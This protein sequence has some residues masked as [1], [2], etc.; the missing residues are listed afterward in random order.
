MKFVGG[1]KDSDVDQAMSKACQKCV[2]SIY[3]NL[4][5]KKNLIGTGTIVHLF[6]GFVPPQI[7]KMVASKEFNVPLGIVL[8]CAHLIRND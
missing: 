7:E 4:K 6:G 3:C 8:T 2:G 5:G 1:L